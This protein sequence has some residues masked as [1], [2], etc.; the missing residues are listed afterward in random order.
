MLERPHER[1]KLLKAGYSLNKIE[2]IYILD[3]KALFQNLVIL[4]FIAYTDVLDL[5]RC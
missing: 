5:C 2:E 1:V 4:V 3:H